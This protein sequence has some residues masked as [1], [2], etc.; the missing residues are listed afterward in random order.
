MGMLLLVTGLDV[1]PELQAVT[2]VETVL[3]IGCGHTGEPHV[4]PHG[5]LGGTEVLLLIGDDGLGGD[6]APARD[7][8]AVGEDTP[9]AVVQEDVFHSCLLYVGG[10]LYRGYLYRRA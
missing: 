8:H 5:L 2:L 7:R 4:L 1:V 9:V 6:V 10:C 3:T